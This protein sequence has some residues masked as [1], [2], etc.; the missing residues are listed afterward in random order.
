[1]CLPLEWKVMSVGL[2]AGALDSAA[3]HVDI[4][5]HSKGGHTSRPHLTADLIYAIGPVLFDDLIASR[6]RGVHIF[7]G[8]VIISG[9][10]FALRS[11]Y[12]SLP[13]IL[14]ET[15][16]EK[17]YLVNSPV[18]LFSALMIGS[19]FEIANF[20]I[21]SYQGFFVDIA[22]IRFALIISAMV[23]SSV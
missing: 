22:G 6:K 17:L 11:H 13:L 1:M 5:F 15:E 9:T 23:L 10:L 18:V 12:P 3:D 21:K 14:P 16:R 4:T 20:K 8:V 2:R 19:A 7:I